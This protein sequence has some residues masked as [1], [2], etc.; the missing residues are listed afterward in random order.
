MTQLDASSSL[1]TPQENSIS[2]RTVLQ[3]FL[4]GKKK[5]KTYSLPNLTLCRPRGWHME[6]KHVLVDG[7]P[8]SASIFDFGLF[9][10]HNAKEQIKRG[11]GPYFYLP[12]MESHLEARY[13]KLSLY[14][15]TR[16]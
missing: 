13:A 11:Y 12:K 1:R 2:S 5:K 15:I 3:Y 6:E 8:I 16:R 9:F 7:E 14:Y 4:L 10:F